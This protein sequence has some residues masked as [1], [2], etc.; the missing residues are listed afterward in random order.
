VDDWPPIHHLLYK[1]EKK[2]K[3][4]KKEKKNPYMGYKETCEI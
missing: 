2:E 1:I 3:R 4:E